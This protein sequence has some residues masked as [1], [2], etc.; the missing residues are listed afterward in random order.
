MCVT[1]LNSRWIPSLYLQMA[2]TAVPSSHSHSSKCLVDISHHH[3]IPHHHHPPNK[4]KA[5]LF[6][7]FPKQFFLLY[8]VSILHDWLSPWSPKPEKWGW[9]LASPRP[10]MHPISSHSLR[11]W[12]V[13]P[14]SLLFTPSPLF[15][16]LVQT[17]IIS[18][19]GH[20]SNILNILSASSFYPPLST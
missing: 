6:S 13:F 1:W 11:E 8:H 7:S 12:V 17:L 20:S 3:L 9:V 14:K 5:N 15:F 19:L 2:W 4:S 18:Y 10:L 16:K